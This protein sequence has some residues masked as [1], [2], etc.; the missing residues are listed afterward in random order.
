MQT[1]FHDFYD[2]YDFYDSISMIYLDIEG[3]KSRPGRYYYFLLPNKRSFQ[4]SA[5]Y[6]TTSGK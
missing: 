2:F 4:D 6:S 5:Q 1:I 3:G